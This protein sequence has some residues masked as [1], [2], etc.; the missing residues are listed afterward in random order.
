MAAGGS[1]GFVDSIAGGGGIITLP[2][3]LA[4]GLPPTL[5]LGTNKLQSS[6]GS[7]TASV[8]YGAAGL[9]RPGDMAPGILAT[10]AGAGLGA[11][12]VGAIDAGLLR[13]LVPSLLLGILLFLA[14]RPRFGLQGG[15]R[16]LPLLPFWIGSGLV[17]GFY[18]GFFGPG[19][20]TFWAMAL[21]G[22]A[23]LDLREATARTKVV[24]FASNLVSLAIFAT[25]GSVVV[26]VGL[27]MGAAEVAGAW[28]GSRMVLK[29]GAG[30]VR[31]MT[32][33]VTAAMIAYVVLRYWAKVI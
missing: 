29:R 9:V 8:R 21:V 1:A 11:L 15:A 13:F 31:G 14:L 3:L 5:A 17:L 16:K 30:L 6:F 33:G 27:A 22:L 32:L 7:L 24:N 23:G 28:A 25:A 12:A 20:G 4:A 26:A 19:T 2:A 10:A 18:D